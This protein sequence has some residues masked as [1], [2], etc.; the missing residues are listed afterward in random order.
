MLEFLARLH[1]GVQIS[2][3][4]T[5]IGLVFV[6]QFFIRKNRTSF[7]KTDYFDV[8]EPVYIPKREI[9]EDLFYKPDVSLLPVKD[10]GEGDSERPSAAAL[11]QVNAL[12][13]ASAKMI[14]L[15]FPL[16]NDEIKKE[17]GTANLEFVAACEENYTRFMQAMTRWAQTLLDSGEY[18]DAELVLTACVNG[19][20]DLSKTYIMLADIYAVA[21]NAEKLNELYDI[22]M[23]KKINSKE[24][25]LLHIKKA[26]SGLGDK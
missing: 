24:K 3:I 14:R 10:Y 25:V 6:I 20:S 12:N 22:A 4:L 11:T 7:K 1:V 2:A 5:T 26:I 19:G 21:D 23:D 17:F 18:G 15:P 13:C 16:T 9:S 8:V